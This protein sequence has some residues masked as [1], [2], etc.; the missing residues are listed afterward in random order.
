MIVFRQLS[1]IRQNYGD[2]TKPAKLRQR[3]ATMPNGVRAR[4]NS[5]HA[6]RRRN[7][8]RDMAVR[9][10]LV[11]EAPPIVVEAEPIS[12]QADP[13]TIQQLQRRIGELEEQVKK[14]KQNYKSA[15]KAEK[16]LDNMIINISHFLKD[17]CCLIGKQP[18]REGELLTP[19]WL[20]D[21]KNEIRALKQKAGHYD[22]WQKSIAEHDE[23]GAVALEDIAKKIEKVNSMEKERDAFGDASRSF[24]EIAESAH[25]DML[26]AEEKYQKAIN[27]TLMAFQ[28]TEI[29]DLQDENDKLMKL[30]KS[31]LSIKKKDKTEI[32][33][34]QKIIQNMAEDFHTMIEKL[35]KSGAPGATSIN[36]TTGEVLREY[37][38]TNK[39][40]SE[41]SMVG[42][43]NNK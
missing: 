17:S 16:N 42:F 37:V 11:R 15:K 23:F 9:A 10:E 34:Y 31:L 8:Q 26:I 4:G 36:S 27:G 32:E 20:N 25:D 33:K 3:N 39:L 43:Y 28:E 18:L 13:D 7:Q 38:S 29:K 2:R 19:E 21:F 24:K 30:N 5:R 6:N 1:N 35:H 40:D 41:W 14:V 22:T 12:V